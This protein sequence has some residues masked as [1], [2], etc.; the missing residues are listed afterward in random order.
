MVT[1]LVFPRLRPGTGWAFREVARRHGDFAL[2]A[3]AVLLSFQGD[4]IASARVGIAG[5]GGRP[6]RVRAAEALL[7]GRP[8]GPD[9]WEAAAEQVARDV[10]PT[11]DIHASADYRRRAAAVLTRRALAEAAGRAVA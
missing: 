9:A 2:V 4:R 6:V 11:G 5:C 7:E 8:A 1:E 3:V 10:Q